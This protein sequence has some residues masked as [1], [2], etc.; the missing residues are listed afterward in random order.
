VGSRRG[1]AIWRI[2]KPTP[3]MGDAR[4]HILGPCETPCSSNRLDMLE[5]VSAPNLRIPFS[6]LDAALPFIIRRDLSLRIL[7]LF[8]AVDDFMLSFT[9]D[10]RATQIA[11]G[12]RR[13]RA[14]ELWPSEIM[15][16][17]IHFHQSHYRTWKRV[18][19]RICTGTSEQG[20]PSF[21]QLFSLCC[22]HP[23]GDDPTTGLLTEPV[24]GLHRHQLH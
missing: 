15:T 9:P 4:S 5:R 17:L 24:W 3:S 10:W 7:E 1:Q 16:I 6:G 11:G 12:K 2:V 8:C 13:Q 21:G 23:T 19:H 20:I 22:A 14:G 18:L